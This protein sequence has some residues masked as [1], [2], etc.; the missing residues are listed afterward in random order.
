MSRENRLLVGIRNHDIVAVF[1]AVGAFFLVYEM[2]DVRE[3]VLHGG[4]ATRILATD[5]ILHSVRY[6][7]LHL[8]DGFPVFDDVHRRVRVN[9]SQEIVVDVND[10]VDLDNVFLA[11][12]LTVG[13]ADEGDI[14]IG[15]VEVQ[16]IEHLD[17][18]SGGNVVDDNTFF[19]AGDF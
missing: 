9:Q 19:Y 2:E 7:Q 1:A 4:D 6:F 11:H 10:I 17:A 12:L 15:L 8:L 5:D 3:V 18:I 13:V 14:I 16:I